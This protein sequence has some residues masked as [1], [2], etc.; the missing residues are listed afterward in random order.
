MANAYAAARDAWVD[1]VL[2]DVLGWGDCYTTD[3]ASLPIAPPVAT[4]QT[5]RSAYGP[6]GRS[7]MATSSA[8]W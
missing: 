8:R 6:P 1:V 7:F 2:R 4:P 5:S 3:L